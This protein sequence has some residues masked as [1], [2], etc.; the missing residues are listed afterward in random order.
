MSD[1]RSPTSLAGTRE[2][3]AIGANS[4][5]ERDKVRR[6]LA[7]RVRREIPQRWNDS[8]A[9]LAELIDMLGLH[10]DFDAEASRMISR[11]TVRDCSPVGETITTRRARA[12]H[13]VV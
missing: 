7:N 5:D 6:Y 10:T 9:E 11:T 4:V 8:K 1:V 12:S 13:Q 2:G 3:C